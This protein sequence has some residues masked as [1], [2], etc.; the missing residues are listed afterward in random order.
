MSNVYNRQLAFVK[1]PGGIRQIANYCIKLISCLKQNLY[2]ISLQIM[3]E[4]PVLFVQFSCITHI[5]LPISNRWIANYTFYRWRVGVGAARKCFTIQ[6]TS[7]YCLQIPTRFTISPTP[8]NFGKPK[9]NVTLKKLDAKSQAIFEIGHC[10]SAI[11][12]FKKTIFPIRS[13]P[14]PI[15][16]FDPSRV[17]RYNR[18]TRQC[19]AHFTS[20]NY[21]QISKTKPLDAAQPWM[22][23]AYETCVASPAGVI[24]FRRWCRTRGQRAAWFAS[25]RTHSSFITIC[26]LLN[27]GVYRG[28]R[29]SGSWLWVTN[30]SRGRLNSLAG[31]K[32]VRV[33]RSLRKRAA[34]SPSL[35]LGNETWLRRPGRIARYL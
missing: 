5:K 35:P 19:D 31:K 3:F 29:A 33:R 16:P 7:P 13:S 23:R 27:Y 22:R 14:S 11:I 4:N 17:L 9:Q 26:K 15:G 34:C 18:I 1:L 30:L 32:Y 21:E 28:W 10:G 2:Y 8:L 12:S 24:K 6:G 25:R 20:T